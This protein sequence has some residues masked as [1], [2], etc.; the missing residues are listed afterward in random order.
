VY[1]AIKGFQADYRSRHAVLMIRKIEIG[2]GREPD[3]MRIDVA[4]QDV[5]TEGMAVMIGVTVAMIDEM[6]EILEKMT[7]EI[8]TIVEMNPDETTPDEMT[9]IEIDDALIGTYEINGIRS[10]EKVF[11]LEVPKDGICAPLI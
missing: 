5:M 9:V 1:T 11:D 10:R 4:S 7:A 2:S 3:V 6:G 8:E